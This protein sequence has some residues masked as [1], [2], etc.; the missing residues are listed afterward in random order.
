MKNSILEIQR[1]EILDIL[2]SGKLGDENPFDLAQE[3]H[4]IGQQIAYNNTRSR[5]IAELERVN[6]KRL[7][8]QAHLIEGNSVGSESD[9]EE[10]QAQ[11]RSL[12]ITLKELD[13]FE[14]RRPKAKLV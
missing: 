2:F 10:Y 13:G 8:E 5:L 6:A 11:I 9:L 3:L 14:E 12:T 7:A 4:E 1:K